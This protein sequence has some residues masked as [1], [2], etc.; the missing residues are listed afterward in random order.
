MCHW[1]LTLFRFSLCA[2]ATLLSLLTPPASATAAPLDIQ[3]T[4]IFR[5]FERDTLTSKDEMVAPVYEYLRADFGHENNKGLSLH[6][7]GWGRTDLAGSD[8][9]RDDSTAELLYGY[10]EYAHPASNLNL[11]LG[12]QQVVA[13]IANDSIDGLS[14]FSDL[15]SAFSLSAYGGLPVAFSTVQGRSGDHIYG[16]RFS[17]HLKSLYD[18]GLSYQKLSDDD[19]KQD[20]QLGIDASLGLAGVTLAG[21]SSYNL[22]SEGWGEHFYEVRAALGDFS[23]RPFFEKYDYRDYFASGNRTPNPFAV[24][25]QSSEGLTSYGADLLWRAASRW[26]IGAK[27][28]HFTYQVNDDTADYYAGFLTWHGAELTQIGGEVGKMQGDVAKNEYLLSR[29]FFYWDH[30]AARP[31][32]FISGDLL[33]ALYDQEIYGQDSSFFASLG[34]GQRF[35]KDRFELKLSGDYSDNPNYDSDVRGMLVMNYRFG[36]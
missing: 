13:G 1:R 5:L 34:A 3:S 7:Y 2:T 17:H 27:G 28:K 12:R 31:G 9:Y 21:R 25:T 35:F 8:F 32:L 36:L 6:L 16:G 4:T 29:L 30:P 10:L 24:L 18:L 22:E 15:G 26:D 14:L 20:E 33:Y 23:I 11:R 19:N